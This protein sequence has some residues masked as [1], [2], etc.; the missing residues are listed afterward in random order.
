[1]E[2]YG[3]DTESDYTS[4]WRDWVSDCDFLSILLRHLRGNGL[5][6]CVSC[7]ALVVVLAQ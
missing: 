7:N 3:T 4:Y 5:V 1:M 2:E 6:V